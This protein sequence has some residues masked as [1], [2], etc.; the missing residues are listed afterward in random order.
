MDYGG[1]IGLR[2]GISCNFFILSERKVS[3]IES[4]G[5]RGE[6]REFALMGKIENHSDVR[7]DGLKRDLISFSLAPGASTENC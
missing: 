1:E 4:F 7:L 5:E 3:W 6:E 2:D